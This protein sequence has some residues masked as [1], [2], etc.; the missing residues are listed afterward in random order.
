MNWEVKINQWLA[1]VPQRQMRWGLSLVL[2]LVL[3]ILLAQ[4]TLLLLPKESGKGSWKP[5][6]VKVTADAGG[7]DMDALRQLLL[8]GD[9][10]QVRNEK[11]TP[12]VAPKTKLQ[13]K[14][15][16]ITATEDPKRG[17]AVIESKGKQSTYGVDERIDG[18]QATVAEIYPDRVMIRNGGQLEALVLN[19]YDGASFTA[20]APPEDDDEEAGEEFALKRR[21][22]PEA[23]EQLA[24]A[25]DDV[26]DADGAD[27]LARL[28]DYINISPVRS[29]EELIGFRVNP[30]KDKS[31]F[32][33]IGLEPGDLAT[34][35]NGYDLTDMSQ[36][37]EVMSE[38]DS[39]ESLTLSVERDGQLYE[40]YFELPSQ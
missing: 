17:S 30:G 20:E 24:E 4:I 1:A 25:V 32:E 15:S 11:P 13:L 27:R 8:F 9:A 3:V 26:R 36:T 5:S 28:T 33:A 35:L 6:P 22:P 16:G 21:P 12:T 40:F 7:Q 39:M 38:L 19:D 34:S 18:T 10:T 2:S 31:L 14:L 29:G 37:A 23:A